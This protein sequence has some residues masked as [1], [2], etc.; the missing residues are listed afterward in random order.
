MKAFI[1]KL[2]YAIIIRRRAAL[3]WVL[4]WQTAESARESWQDM[5]LS[6]LSPSDAVDEELSCWTE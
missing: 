3:P 4:A 6:P 5:P 1:W 2:Q